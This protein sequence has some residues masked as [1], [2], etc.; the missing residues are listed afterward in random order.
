MKDERC[1]AEASI[2]HFKRALIIRSFCLGALA[3]LRESSLRLG[4]C[5]LLFVTGFASAGNWDRFRGPNGA[6]QSDE[7]GIPTK[8]E[9]KNFVWK[10]PLVGV[11]H[12]SP[13][14]WEG[15]VFITSADPKSGK[16]IVSAIDAKTGS[17]LWQKEFDA[18]EYHKNG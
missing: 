4:V 3:P 6:G 10:R 13:V 18:G 14:I 12:S 2:F 5:L 9:E 16:Q 11:G 17:S 8:W 7:P 15:R 1:K